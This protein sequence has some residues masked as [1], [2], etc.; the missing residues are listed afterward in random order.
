MEFE[1]AQ[2]QADYADDQ[3]F[4]ERVIDY[5]LDVSPNDPIVTWLRA[6]SVKSATTFAVLAYKAIKTWTY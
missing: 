2:Q 5:F 6:N 4:I 3:L 1:S